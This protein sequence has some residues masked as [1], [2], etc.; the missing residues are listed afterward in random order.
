MVVRDQ[1]SINILVGPAAVRKCSLERDYSNDPGLLSAA[2]LSSSTDLTLDP[3]SVAV[4]LSRSNGV[5]RF[6]GK[7]IG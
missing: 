3:F 7:R 2:T 6:A 1:T 4:Y 5:D